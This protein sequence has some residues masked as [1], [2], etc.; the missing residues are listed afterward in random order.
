MGTKSKPLL[1]C[2][3]EEQESEEKGT[4]LGLSI[5]LVSLCW[6]SPVLSA[7]HAM[8]VTELIRLGRS[9]WSGAEVGPFVVLP[10][11]CS[12]HES[13][14]DVS[15][16]RNARRVSPIEMKSNMHFMAAI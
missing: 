7:V 8:E 16:W 5:L 2:G 10:T 1:E 14:S 12:H 13:H 4:A 6:K 15:S 11:I 9:W 3:Y